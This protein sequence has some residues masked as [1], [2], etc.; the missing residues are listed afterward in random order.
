M[1][2]TLLKALVALLPMALLFSGSMLLFRKGRTIQASLQ[3]LGTSCLL[4]VVLTH[5]FEALHLF[6]WMGWGVQES[7]GHYVDL[8][9]AVLGLALFPIGYLLHA[10]NQ[11]K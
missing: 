7:A 8:S 2:V 5:V 11:W 6:P 3:L 9:S 4:L 10:L 1:N